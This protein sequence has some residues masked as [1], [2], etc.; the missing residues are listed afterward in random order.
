MKRIGALWIK[1]S[2]KVGEYLSGVLDL[3]A[4]GETHITV[5]PNKNKEDESDQHPDYGIFVTSQ[6]ESN[7]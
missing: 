5:L 3:G 7:S 4:V 6:R 2:N 1:N